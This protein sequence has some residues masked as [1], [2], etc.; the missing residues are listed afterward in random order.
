MILSSKRLHPKREK[1]GEKKENRY[2]ASWK[3]HVPFS[4]EWC[5]PVLVVLRERGW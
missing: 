2:L 4:D 5:G 3:E 1:K